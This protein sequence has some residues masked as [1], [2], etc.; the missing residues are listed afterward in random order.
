MRLPNLD[1]LL[2]LIAPKVDVAR[3][4]ALL[5]DQFIDHVPRHDKFAE[6]LCRLV[7][8]DLPIRPHVST[9]V[10]RVLRV[11]VLNGDGNESE[12]ASEL[13]T[14]VARVVQQFSA[15]YPQETDAGVQAAVASFEPSEQRPKVIG[16][17][18]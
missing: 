18:V 9:A 7:S 5:I 16:W 11:F 12:S 17:E 6:D 13:R 8:S 3:V 10:E 15:C 1:E 4:A 14:R 2:L